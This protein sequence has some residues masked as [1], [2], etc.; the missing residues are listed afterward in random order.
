M[1][2][3]EVLETFKRTNALLDE[4]G[5]RRGVDGIRRTAD[6]RPW[7]YEI[8][9]VSGWSDWVRASQVIARDFRAAGIDAQIADVDAQLTESL[10]LLKIVAGG[11]AP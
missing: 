4:A 8:I 2:Q 3:T 6:G 5:Y 11:G 9:T 10:V 7:K 1:K